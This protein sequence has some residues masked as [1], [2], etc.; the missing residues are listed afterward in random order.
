[1]LERP[2]KAAT[3]TA[4][5]HPRMAEA[6]RVIIDQFDGNLGEFFATLQAEKR[7]DREHFSSE[8]K[9]LVEAVSR[10]L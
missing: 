7:S 10:S 9:R 4:S 3:E 8:E 5:L 1:M 2:K 6:V